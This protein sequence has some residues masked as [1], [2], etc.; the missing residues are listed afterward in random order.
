MDSA[1]GQEPCLRKPQYEAVRERVDEAMERLR[2]RARALRQLRLQRSAKRLEITVVVRPVAYARVCVDEVAQR[3]GEVGPK[4]ERLS[5]TWQVGCRR[6]CVDLYVF[7]S[8]LSLNDSL[9]LEN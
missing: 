9:F 3:V 8:G 4:L 1:C 7:Q 2:R 6:E 5:Y